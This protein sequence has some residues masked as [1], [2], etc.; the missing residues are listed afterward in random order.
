MSDLLHL[1]TSIPG[2]AYALHILPYKKD[3]FYSMQYCKNNTQY[4]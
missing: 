1:C 4:E 3:G 2:G